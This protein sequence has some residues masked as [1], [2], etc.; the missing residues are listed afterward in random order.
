MEVST[1]SVE[2]V[3]DDKDLLSVVQAMQAEM[4]KRFKDL[5]QRVVQAIQ[6][7]M[8]KR[9]KDLEERVVVMEKKL[10]IK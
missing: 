9:F 8:N 1:E 10:S 6:A 5:E 4:N 7:E 3:G 2:K